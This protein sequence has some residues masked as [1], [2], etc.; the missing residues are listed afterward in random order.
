MNYIKIVKNNC[1]LVVIINQQFKY[2]NYFDILNH[3]KIYTMDV[4]INHNLGCLSFI[5]VT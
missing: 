4:I 2:Y 3:S 5:H 1:N